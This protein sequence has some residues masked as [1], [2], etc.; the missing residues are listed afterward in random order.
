[1]PRGYAS[2][3]AAGPFG[4]IHRRRRRLVD[5]LIGCLLPVAG[6]L[7]P[8]TGPLKDAAAGGPQCLSEFGGPHVFPG[9]YHCA[10]VRIE[11]LDRRGEL[12]V[13]VSAPE[14]QDQVLDRSDL[15]RFSFFPQHAFPSPAWDNI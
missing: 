5:C 12:V 8:A 10:R 2:S 6:I 4:H 3:L 15:H 9:N 1:M 7:A 14:S 11:A 13:N